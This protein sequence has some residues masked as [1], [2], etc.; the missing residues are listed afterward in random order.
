M[1]EM[2]HNLSDNDRSSLELNLELYVKNVNIP[3][4][5]NLCYKRG[6]GVFAIYVL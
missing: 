3:I 2:T 1:Y 5:L 6:K 4:I